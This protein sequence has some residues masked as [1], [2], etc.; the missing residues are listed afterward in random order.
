[1][2]MVSITKTIF[3]L[4][5]WIL[6]NVSPYQLVHCKFS[7]L[8]LPFR[9]FGPDSTAFDAKGDGPYTGVG[10]GRVLKYQGPNIG[11][12]EFAI[13]SPNRIKARCDG[14]NDPISQRMC[15]RPY[16]LGFYFKTG[17]LYITD[18]Y[19]GLLVVR[20]SGGQ[21]TQL[22]TGF[23]GK[24]FGFLDSL[25]IDQEKGIVYF[26][27]SGAI[28]KTRLLFALSGDTT[29]RLYKYDI[30]TKKVTLLLTG[31]SGPA[32]VALSK[33][34]SYLLITESIGRR[35][36]R[37]WLKGA[38]ANS[39]DVFI[40]V[41]GNPDNIK[42]T[43]SGDFWVAIVSIN[44]QL[45]PPISSIGQR[46]NQFGEVEETRDFTDL[47]KSPTGITEVH[48]YKGKLYI[49]SLV[50]NFVGLSSPT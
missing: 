23:D 41:D 15:G 3:L 8:E 27:D 21:A 18:A 36:R 33:D 13:T 12:T 42:M 16:G 32:G 50:H 17:D 49:G 35:I 5:I 24:P 26:I 28:F 39:S 25:D 38:Q 45:I 40:N 47:F 19:Y 22:V 6:V 29:G 46:I 2:K 30:R 11:F 7:R 44:K 10:D 34:N 48:E 43:A 4:Q 1:M 20:P 9:T 31:L 14:T 37:F